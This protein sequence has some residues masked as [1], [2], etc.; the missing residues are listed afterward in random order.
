M[1]SVFL[2]DDEELVIKS[3][4][5][6]VDWASHGFIV[7]G[8]ALCATDALLQIVDI[9]PDVVFTDIRMP[10]MSGLELIKQ[11][12]DRSFP[13]LKIVISGYAEFAL[14]QKAINYGAFGYCLKPFDETEIITFLKKAETVLQD[15]T[16][17]REMD[18]WS[19]GTNRDS[20]IIVPNSTRKEK[21]LDQLENAI[22]QNDWAGVSVALE[23]LE[24]F[25]KKN[26]LHITDALWAY[27]Q[28]MR[29]IYKNE[30]EAFAD[31]LIFSIDQ[32]TGSFTSALD[33]LTYLQELLADKYRQAG[34]QHQPGNRTFMAI[35]SFIDEHYLEELSI[36]SLAKQ[37]SVNGNYISQLFKR[38]TGSTFTEYLTQLRMKHAC[39]ILLKT[40][41]PISEVAENSGYTDYFYFS[42]IFKRT[43]GI[44]PSAY[45][46]RQ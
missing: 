18:F 37:F 25:F 42:R 22:A 29:F 2:V 4:I 6:S 35:R 24:V 21:G 19:M 5:A 38:V 11:L 27:N 36:P 16:H 7:A 17:Q 15:R 1:Y 43:Q 28:V 26:S 39:E 45:R 44:T 20:N 33:M 12:N 32:L 31:T 34:S 13:G 9:S 10:G 14:A 8:Y 30:K 23:Q 46:N 40:D 41:L 3:L